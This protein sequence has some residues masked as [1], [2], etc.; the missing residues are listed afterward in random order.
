V[1]EAG[2]EVFAGNEPVVDRGVGE[3][4]VDGEPEPVVVGALELVAATDGDELDDPGAAEEL[5]DTGA[6]VVV[7][8][9][10]ADA[11]VAAQEQI[12]LAAD[13]TA[14]AEALQAASTQPMAALWMAEY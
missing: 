4:V 3:E 9:A 10:E 13:R 5:V 6:E 12:A 1:N 8:P 11:A 7:G 2:V 14:G